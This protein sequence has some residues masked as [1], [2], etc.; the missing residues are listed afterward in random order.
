MQRGQTSSASQSVRLDTKAAFREL[1]RDVKT[2]LSLVKP[3]KPLFLE[4]DRWVRGMYN[5]F[6][7][8][9]FGALFPYRYFANIP[10]S[11]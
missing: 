7:H 6:L 3:H 5:P 9:S 2:P 1:C 10:P 11:G 8:P 4:T